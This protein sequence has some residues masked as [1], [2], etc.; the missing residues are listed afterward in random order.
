MALM[1]EMNRVL[2]PGGPLLLTTP[3]LASAHAVEQTLRA[4]SPYCYGQ[5]EVGGRIT[6]RHNR[7]YTA[8]EV[9]AVAAD[10]GF[11]TISPRPR[12]FFLP[13][14]RETP[15][16]PPGLGLPLSLPGGSTFLL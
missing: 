12:G 8:A 5:F 6:D 15:F 2:K 16:H 1:A 9:A 13:P 4:E 10:A 3:N 7:E 11:E 14:K